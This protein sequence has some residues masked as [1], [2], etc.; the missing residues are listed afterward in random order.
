[1]LKP[2]LRG[3]SPVAV[4]AFVNIRKVAVWVSGRIIVVNIR[5]RIA[6]VCDTVTNKHNPVAV[7]KLGNSADCVSLYQLRVYALPAGSTLHPRIPNFNLVNPQ[8]GLPYGDTRL[9]RSRFQVCCTKRLPAIFT[10][11]TYS[12]CPFDKAF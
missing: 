5:V 1:M 9:I 3:N 4:D 7:L 2:F 6:A 12:R 10:V 11:F 8:P